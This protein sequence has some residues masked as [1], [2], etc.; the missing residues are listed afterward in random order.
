[1]SKRFKS[2]DYRRFKKLGI[3]WRRPVGRHSKLKISK[4]GSGIVPRIGYRTPNAVRFMARINDSKGVSLVKTHLI[5][6]FNE[7]EKVPKG[8][9]IILA[10][11]IGK[12][13]VVMIA[14]KANQLGLHVVNSQKARAAKRM[15]KTIAYKKE[16][17]KV[18]TK[19]VKA[20]E[21]KNETSE[22]KEEKGK[23]AKAEAGPSME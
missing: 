12:K 1:M 2:Q 14:E 4:G 13:K 17:N 8:E 20:D 23:E 10:S 9:H 22:K 11:N 19:S 16:I 18:K 21:K 3:R 15:Q 7:L 6:S 5:H